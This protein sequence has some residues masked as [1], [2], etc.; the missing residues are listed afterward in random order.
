MLREL[1]HTLNVFF[2]I[3]ILLLK[4]KK[5]T[6]FCKKNSSKLN[7][8]RHTRHA[9]V[10]SKKDVSSRFIAELFILVLSVISHRVFI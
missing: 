7:C 10:F 6:I 8:W 4:D 3:R 5:E 9:C 2:Y 1:I